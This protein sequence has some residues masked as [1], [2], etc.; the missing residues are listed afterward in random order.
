VRFTIVVS[1]FAGLVKRINFSYVSLA[2]GVAIALA[3]YIALRGS[4][5]TPPA[6]TNRPVS[7]PV[8]AA[9][10][11]ADPISV[12][13]YV[14]YLVRSEEERDSFYQAASRN[15]ARW[16]RAWILVVEDHFGLAARQR[17]LE[18]EG[19]VARV[20]EQRQ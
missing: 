1:R 3:G 16:D 20:V 12:E 2:L 14:Y 4:P 7:A 10:P 5:A 17:Q 18:E 15:G 6:A 9:L 13:P 19:F 11:A 8:K